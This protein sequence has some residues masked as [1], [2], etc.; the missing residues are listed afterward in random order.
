[1][2]DNITSNLKLHIENRKEMKPQC[3]RPQKNAYNIKNVRKYIKKKNYEKLCIS[4]SA[5]TK[6]HTQLSISCCQICT[7]KPG[8]TNSNGNQEFF[9]HQ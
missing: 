9:E 2:V 3:Y 4:D 8:L 7:F 6:R 1:M 5:K